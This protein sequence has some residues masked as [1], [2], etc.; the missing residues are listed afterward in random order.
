MPETIGLYLKT[1][2]DCPPTLASLGNVLKSFDELAGEIS[3]IVDPSSKLELRI[4]SIEEG[5]I[6]IESFVRLANQYVP[7][8]KQWVTI[9]AVALFSLL[10]DV[11]SMIVQEE[12]K[13]I[14]YDQ[15]FNIPDEQI[16]EIAKKVVEFHRKGVGKP[17]AREFLQH[18]EDENGI[19]GAGIII[20][21]RE[22]PKRIIN[23]LEIRAQIDALEDALE[24]DYTA[25]D[26]RDY[27][28]I[29][30]LLVLSPFLS[31]EKRRW[32][33]QDSY[34]EF[35]AVVEDKAFLGRLLNG[36]LSIPM[37]AGVVIKARIK[38]REELVDGVWQNPTYK[39]KEVLSIVSAAPEQTD[40]F[41]PDNK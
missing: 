5:S 20:A 8:K 33:F 2:T 31:T 17:Q 1:N 15:E 21:P 25:V 39:V 27:E 30:D 38:I 12:A 16:E 29:R 4:S 24:L 35:G 34:R 18:I 22:K 3:F 32:K 13:K 37:R 23:R 40:L 19:E 7:D 26:V 36:Q 6:R 14:I 10:G 28:H 9:I 41:F 11:R